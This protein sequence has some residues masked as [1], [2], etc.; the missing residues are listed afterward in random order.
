MNRQGAVN[1]GNI[2]SEQESRKDGG[3]GFGPRHCLIPRQ[4]VLS[5]TWKPG[6]IWGRMGPTVVSLR[7]VDLCANS[8]TGLKI[9]WVRL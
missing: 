2:R 9:C 4:N 5:S 1:L 3:F 6:A 8:D 7:A